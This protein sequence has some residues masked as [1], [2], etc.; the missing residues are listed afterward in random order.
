VDEPPA[1]RFPVRLYVPPEQEAGTYAQAAVV[2]HTPYDFTIDFA[3]MQKPHPA[4]AEDSDSPLVVP[5]RV[6][7][8]VRIPWGSRST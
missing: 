3:A 2:W 8:R 1:G 6:V 4:D 7:A 5:A